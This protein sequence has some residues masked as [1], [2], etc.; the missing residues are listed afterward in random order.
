MPDELAIQERTGLETKT[1]LQASRDEGRLYIAYHDSRPVLRG[2]H[3]VPIHVGR[4]VSAARLDGIEGDDTGDNISALNAEYCELT[5][6]YWAWRNGPPAGI[7]GLMHYRRLFDLSGRLNAGGH[8]ER[9]VIDFDP[10]AYAN[11]V[12]DHFAAERMLPDLIVPRP[13]H[14]RLDV[15]TH[16]RKLHRSADLEILRAVVA[17]RR[18]DFLP[19][20]DRT[21]AGRRL[22]VGNMFIMTRRLFEDYSRL[23]FDILPEARARIRATN[24]TAAMGY[25]G[26]YPGFL[27]ER[28]LTAYALGDLVKTQFPGVQPDYRGV[29]NTDTGALSGIGPSGLLRLWARG[30]LKPGDALSLWGKRKMPGQQGNRV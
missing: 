26:R 12:A 28:I 15:A 7:V 5:A 20:L 17:E 11:D 18:P 30:R 8:H 10:D 16:Y 2:R 29:V 3:L 9:Y 1:S 14:L 23:L 22:L 4:A 27:A 6:H 25:Q 21:L 19:D 24:K 13:I